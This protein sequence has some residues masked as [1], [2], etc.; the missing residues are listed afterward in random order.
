MVTVL[1]VVF[2]I[3]GTGIRGA[4]AQQNPC[5]AVSSV[6]SDGTDGITLLNSNPVGPPGGFAVQGLDS[7]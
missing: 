7:P 2:A 4:P 5:A 6:K 1:S 3:L